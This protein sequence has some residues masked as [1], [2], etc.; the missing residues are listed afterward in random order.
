MVRTYL[1]IKIRMTRTRMMLTVS[2]VWP[3]KRPQRMNMRLKILLLFPP[4][5]TMTTISRLWRSFP[6]S[7]HPSRQSSR[8]SSTSNESRKLGSRKARQRT[9]SSKSYARSSHRIKSS[10]A[11]TPL[12]SSWTSTGTSTKKTNSYPTVSRCSRMKTSGSRKL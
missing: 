3:Q 11:A 12:S 8:S 1:E 7:W 10:L 5:H 9:N 2:K 6:R 4:S